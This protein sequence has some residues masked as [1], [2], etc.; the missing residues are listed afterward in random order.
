MTRKDP[1]LDL[2]AWQVAF[3]GAEPV[4]NETLGRFADHFASC[5][6]RRK[7]FYPVYGLAEAS[8]KVTSGEPGAGARVCALDAA[9]LAQS[10]VVP[11][12]LEAG[13]RNIVSCGKPSR[14]H[15]ILIADPRSKMPRSAGQIGEIWVAGPSVATGYWRNAEATRKTFKALLRTGQGPY[16]RTGDIGFLSKGELFIT[17]RLKDCIIIRG[18]NHY[19]QDIERTAE[20]AHPALRKH[21]SAAFSLERDGQERLVIVSEL[22]RKHRSSPDEA[23]DAVRAAIARVHD[24]QAFAVVFIKSGALPRTSSGKVQRHACKRKW[25]ES[26][27]PVVSESVLEGAAF[28]DSQPEVTPESLLGRSDSERKH[29]VE[30]YVRRQVARA[31]RC[32]IGELSDAHSLIS[33]GADS[34]AGFDLMQRIERDLKVAVSIGGLL[35]RNIREIAEMVLESLGAE[36][37]SHNGARSFKRIERP[38]RVSLSAS[39]SQVWFLQQ[40]FPDSCAYNEHLLIRLGGALEVEAVER[41]AA[42]MVRRHEILRTTFPMSEGYPHQVVLPFDLEKLPLLHTADLEGEGAVED[43][44]RALV[45]RETQ[46]PFQLETDRPM[47]LMLL[48]VS[49]QE[50]FLLLVAHHIVCDGAS[51]RVVVQ[52]LGTLYQAYVK[53]RQSPLPELALQY[54]D[55]AVWQQQWLQGAVV[56]QE[57]EYWRKQLAYLEPLDLPTDRPRPAAM[58]H[59]GARVPFDLSPELAEKL[60]ELCQREGV[61]VFM[62]LLAAFQVMLGKYAGQQ[63]VAVGILW[64]TATWRRKT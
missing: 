7:A 35:D 40:L 61:T 2:S 33:L 23:M 41:A 36:A 34:L 37:G 44:L 19:P 32:A 4:R 63:D 62:G 26:D 52:E 60:K 17:G 27:L 9:R 12:A 1:P 8:L 10:E 55:Y 38:S 50:H 28:H 6:F 48:R 47:R 29:I 15:E 16:L 30:D 14:D 45:V 3:N 24:I 22:N 49:E 57:L 42:E 31:L 39:Q 51:L 43:R 59:R 20:D 54:A 56:E 46:R 18:R 11:A 64:P 21:G 5:G 58:S 13:A 25:L 53:G